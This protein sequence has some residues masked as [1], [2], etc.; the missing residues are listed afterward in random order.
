M[1]IH[2]LE[3]T[4]SASEIRTKQF[5][6]LKVFWPDQKQTD[7]IKYFKNIG[8]CQQIFDDQT[9]EMSGRAAWTSYLKAVSDNQKATA[10][11]RP[12]PWKR[13]SKIPD[14]FGGFQL[15]LRDQLEISSSDFH[16]DTHASSNKVAV[17]PMCPQK[18]AERLRSAKQNISYSETPATP[19]K[20]SVFEV[21]Q[22]ISANR[23]DY[24][25]KFD[26][27]EDEQIVNSALVNLLN[28]LWINKQRNG[29]W[30]MKRK[31]F[32]FYSQGTGAGFVARTDGHLRVGNK[33]AAILEV[34]A[35]LRPE[36]AIGDHKIEMQESAQMA[37]WI[38]QEPHSHWASAGCTN[39][40][41]EMNET[42][43]Q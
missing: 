28:A 11:K 38:A 7:M 42:L 40:E 8:F 9:E 30:T 15:V 23:K 27:A 37:L 21:L 32:K 22:E 43:F 25:G 2:N 14:E 29:E 18:W 35:R 13:R 24:G 4:E 5:L 16:N 34:K 10:E 36:N 41:G 39:A 3:T 20:P 1:D 31:E 12:R 33:S 17:T 19:K 6:T 26:D